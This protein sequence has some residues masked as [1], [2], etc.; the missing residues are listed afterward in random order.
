MVLGQILDIFEYSS[1]HIEKQ[2]PKH[3]NSSSLKVSAS[4]DTLL[5][6]RG[7]KVKEISQFT[8]FVLK[9]DNSGPL[10]DFFFLFFKIRP[11]VSFIDL[12][13]IMGYFYP[14]FVKIT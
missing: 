14:F 11:K 12:K 8:H 5:E 9:F 3:K 1:I 13:V 10:L 4:F 6:L 2:R 7:V